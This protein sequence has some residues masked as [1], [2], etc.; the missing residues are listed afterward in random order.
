MDILFLLEEGE[1]VPK[2]AAEG[3]DRHDHSMYASDPRVMC[4]VSSGGYRP[5]IVSG[6]RVLFLVLISLF[7]LFCFL[8]S[9]SSSSCV[10]VSFFSCFFFSTFFFSLCLSSVFFIIMFYL[11]SISSFFKI[12]Y[13]PHSLFHYLFI[14]CFLI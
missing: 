9:L 12:T 3:G 11:L 13:L 5:R 1:A 4:H 8:V 6:L 14:H 10:F 7:L 2:M